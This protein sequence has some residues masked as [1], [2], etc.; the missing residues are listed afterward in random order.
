[1]SQTLEQFQAYQTR[2]EQYDQAIALLY[3]DLQTAAPKD[4]IEAK[5]SAVGY[6]STESFRLSTAD[7]YGSLLKKL[8]AP[9]TSVKKVNEKCVVEMFTWTLLESKNQRQ[10]NYR[11]KMHCVRKRI[12]LRVPRLGCR[13]L[14]QSKRTK[15]TARFG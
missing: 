3:W 6:F 7:E 15:G 10:N 11:R 2:L 8:S 12:S 1:M 9:D 13:L 14:R 5:L 4:S